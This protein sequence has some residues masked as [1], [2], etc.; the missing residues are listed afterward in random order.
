[1]AGCGSTRSFNRRAS[2]G[3]ALYRCSLAPRLAPLSRLLAPPL[4]GDR[5]IPVARL[6]GLTTTA[7][8]ERLAADGV[9]GRARAP[10]RPGIWTAT[11]AASA[12][13]RRPGRRPGALT[14][15]LVYFDSSALVKLVVD[16]EGSDLAASCGTHATPP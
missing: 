7:T 9:I 8:L 5:G 10:A 6:L 2:P 3:I 12:T 1:M 13:R 11:A 4:D 16:E 14:V 15:A